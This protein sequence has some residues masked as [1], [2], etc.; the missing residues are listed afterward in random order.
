MDMTKKGGKRIGIPATIDSKTHLLAM[1]THK[2]RVATD[3][4][5]PFAI[6][7]VRVDHCIRSIRSKPDR[8]FIRICTDEGISGCTTKRC[9]RSLRHHRTI[10]FAVVP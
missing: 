5:K 6:R 2:Q 1:V 9:E 8:E 3:S 7:K 4:D 10:L